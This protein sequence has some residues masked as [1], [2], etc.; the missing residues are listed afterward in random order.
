MTLWLSH[1]CAVQRV[2]DEFEALVTASDTIY[3]QKKEPAAGGARDDLIKSKTIASLCFS[4]D[5]LA[6]TNV[7]KTVLQGACLNFLQVP[8][9]VNKLILLLE[10][11]Q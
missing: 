11:K 9:A 1:C 8:E 6:A 5:M 2:L 7:L 10:S 4:A 3:L